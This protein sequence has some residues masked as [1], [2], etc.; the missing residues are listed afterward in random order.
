MSFRS[1]G[2]TVLRR[3]E[4]MVVTRTRMARESII[5]MVGNSKVCVVVRYWLS[6]EPTKGQGDPD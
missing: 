5:V 4:R 3:Y 6:V 1:S 2:K